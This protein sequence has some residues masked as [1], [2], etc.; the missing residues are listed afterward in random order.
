MAAADGI[1][2][3]HVV[4]SHI[5]YS[6]SH[7][8][9]CG[10]LH[11]WHTTNSVDLGRVGGPLGKT[12][13]S[14][15]TLTLCRRAKAREVMGLMQKVSPRASTASTPGPA[16]HGKVASDLGKVWGFHDLLQYTSVVTIKSSFDPKSGM[17]VECLLYILTLAICP[18]AKLLKTMQNY[19]IELRIIHTIYALSILKI[20]LSRDNIIELFGE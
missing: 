16:K 3:L 20:G 14:F 13:S 8:S 19:T 17:D 5:K 11:V 6:T 12:V 7:W 18:K 1:L 15:R 10:Y 9:M 2:P 4:S